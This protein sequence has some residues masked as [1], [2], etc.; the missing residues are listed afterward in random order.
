MKAR[1][2]N[3]LA[4]AL[5]EAGK[6]D[7][8]LHLVQRIWLQTG[9]R[10]LAIKLLPLGIKFIP[11]KPEIGTAFCESFD[12]VDTFLKGQGNTEVPSI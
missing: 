8:L 4:N 11:F 3:D 10:N 2:L 12:W 9:T 1:V 5:N 6:H 7:Q